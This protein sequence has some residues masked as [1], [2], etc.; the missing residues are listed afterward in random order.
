MR[1]QREAGSSGRGQ[2]W[3]RFV[4]YNGR[5]LG[6]YHSCPLSEETSWPHK[7]TSRPWTTAILAQ[8][9]SP[10][11]QPALNTGSEL[12]PPATHMRS[13]PTRARHCPPRA[14]LHPRACG[15]RRWYG[16]SI[17]SSA[18]AGIPPCWTCDY[19]SLRSGTG[20]RPVSPGR[21]WWSQ[22]V[23]GVMLLWCRCSVS[24]AGVHGR[25][26]LLVFAWKVP[27]PGSSPP[28][29]GETFPSQAQIP[30]KAGK[31][32]PLAAL[33]ASLRGQACSLTGSIHPGL[34]AA[35]NLRVGE[36]RVPVPLSL[37]T[38]QIV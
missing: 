17:A 9:T 2:G 23:A 6:C 15:C 32:F 34:Q 20:S 10:G 37:S 1:D 28:L 25:T 36:G 38:S 21:G 5:A 31:G 30:W 14:S 24:A 18:H 8:Q 11:P 22:L 35:R 27:A 26:T 19:C 29:A 16:A 13:G 7:H 4:F 3:S 12:R 33:T